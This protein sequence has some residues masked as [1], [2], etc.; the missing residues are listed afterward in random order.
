MHENGRSVVQGSREGEELRRHLFGRHYA[1]ARLQQNVRAVRSVH[2]HV[3][4]PQQA[5]HDRSGHGQQQQDQL[6]ARGHAR[7]HRHRRDHLSRSA[8]GPR[9][10]HLA[11]RLLHQIQILDIPI[12]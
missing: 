2:V 12:L 4:L 10:R 5:H 7:V 6:G 8:Q 1:S 9:S 3:L 11:Q